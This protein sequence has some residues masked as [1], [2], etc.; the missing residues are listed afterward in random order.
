M[1]AAQSERNGQLIVAGVLLILF[2]VVCAVFPGLTL[3]S[4]AFMIG[5]GFIVSGA[6]NFINY[7]QEK[8]HLSGSAWL[9]AYGVIDV[10]IGVMFIIHP[11][12]FAVVLPWLIGGCIGV[13][14]VFEIIEAISLKRLSFSLWGWLL[15]SG[16]F[17]L[18]I[19]LLLFMW[20]ELLAFYIAAFAI[21]RGISLII[22]GANNHRFV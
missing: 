21:W 20:P 16:I 6:V 10:L 13:F 8:E 7:S 9:L 14:G 4:M 5:A 1:S 22:L 3:G 2:G 15:F 19:S 12:A 11:I 17:S 18:L